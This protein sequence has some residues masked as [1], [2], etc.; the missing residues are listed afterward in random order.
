MMRTPFEQNLMLADRRGA[1]AAD[2]T[3]RCHREGSGLPARGVVAE[4]TT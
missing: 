2:S 4:V 1:G 3:A